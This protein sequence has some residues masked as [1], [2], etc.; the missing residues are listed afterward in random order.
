LAPVRRRVRSAYIAGLD[1]DDALSAGQRLHERGYASTICY[2]NSSE[3][4]PADVAAAYLATL[5][6]ISKAP[7]D[8]RMSV[9]A[10]ALDF[11]PDLFTPVL[12]SA[13]RDGIAVQFDALWPSSQEPTLALLRDL[14]SRQ[15]EVGFTLPSRWSRS[16]DDVEVALELDLP[17]R[18]TK[19]EWPAKGPHEPDPRA[20][21]LG[22][23]DRLAG[24][25]RKVSIATHDAA[26]VRESVSRLLATDTACELE[27]LFGLPPGRA[28]RAAQQKSVPVR[29]YVPYGNP[30][31]PYALQHVRR[32]PRALWWLAQDLVLSDRKGWRYLG[33][34]DTL[35]GRPASGAGPAGTT[36]PREGSLR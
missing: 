24:R 11:A 30:M 35:A 8:S 31:A 10:P 3:A 27:L 1:L 20:G 5:E 16:V 34:M 9:K 19:G 26:L 22:L 18:V 12:D 4:A 17:V 28:L 15:L 25:A 13:K 36:R 23:V 6:A 14:A 2:W 29:V 7:P 33:R 32:D 21:F